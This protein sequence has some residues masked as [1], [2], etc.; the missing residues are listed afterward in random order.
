MINTVKYQSTTSYKFVSLQIYYKHCIN[1]AAT[2]RYDFGSTLVLHV[3]KTTDLHFVEYG[4]QI[5]G[6]TDVFPGSVWN[7]VQSLD[8]VLRIPSQILHLEDKSRFKKQVQ[9]PVRSKVQV[10]KVT[11]DFITDFNTMEW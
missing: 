3:P 11:A 6:I 10:L 5:K 2:K 7:I 9:N 4:S 8:N 1:A